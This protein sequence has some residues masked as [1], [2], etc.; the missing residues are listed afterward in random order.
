M[1]A[2]ESTVALSLASLGYE[3]TAIDP[4]PYPFDHPRLRVVV[5]NVEDWDPDG[6]V[7]GSAL[8]FHS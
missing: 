5:G 3:V 8:H 7:Y 6:D 2:S 4:R 1:G